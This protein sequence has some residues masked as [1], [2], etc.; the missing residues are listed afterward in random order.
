[1]AYNILTRSK[2]SAE[3]RKIEWLLSDNFAR[4]LFQQS[5]FYCGI[6]PNQRNE[7]NNIDRVNNKKGYINNNVVTC[8]KNCNF[9]KWIWGINN[10]LKKCEHIYFYSN[11]NKCKYEHMFRNTKSKTH[12]SSY[13]KS[14]ER[15]K[16]IWDINEN[17]FNKIKKNKCYICGK[18]NSKIHQ[19]G[20]DRI[21]NNIGYEK[22]NVISCCGDCNRMKKDLDYKYFINQCSKIYKYQKSIRM[23]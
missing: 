22:G 13:K 5:C 19:N 7:L 2:R 1:M 18:Q 6:T 8:C 14:A 3:K 23:F 4:Y 9:M 10:F 21:N 17:L 20:I 12:Y 15:R 11:Y 16:K